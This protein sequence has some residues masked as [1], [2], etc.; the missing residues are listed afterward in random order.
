MAFHG[1]GQAD[2]A[3]ELLE[4]LKE[5]DKTTPRLKT[6]DTYK[7]WQDVLW[8]SAGQRKARYGLKNK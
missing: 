6:Y 8:K 7:P 2:V 5:W 3:E 1:G 4:W